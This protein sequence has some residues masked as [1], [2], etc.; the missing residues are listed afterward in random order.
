[1]F[2]RSKIRELAFARPRFGYLRI[3]AILNRDGV[4]VNKK[5]VY[6]LY[7]EESLCLRKTIAGKRKLPVRSRET[8]RPAEKP[9]QRW[10]IDFISERLTSGRSIR[11]LCVIDQF[12]RKNLAIVARHRFLSRDVINVL[13][14]II[15]ETGAPPESITLDN[16]PEFT[17]HL[18]DAWASTQ[19]IALNF[20][21]PGKPSQNGFIESFNARLRDECLNLQLFHSQ[22]HL[23][24]VADKWR[25]DYNNWR[26]HSA[27]ANAVPDKLWQRF[28]D[29]LENTLS[30]CS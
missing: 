2:L 30:K 8:Q 29:D 25:D 20:I 3:T 17:S 24:A 5:R 13:A 16:G 7:T 22:E 14:G 12:S 10:S 27:I 18:F 9:N 4:R 6:R 1:M 19:R 15:R 26:P 11:A 23:Q 28:Q 21:A